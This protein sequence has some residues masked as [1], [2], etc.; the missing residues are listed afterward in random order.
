MLFRLESS[1]CYRSSLSGYTRLLG[2]DQFW[3][4]VGHRLLRGADNREFNLETG[5]GGSL[6]PGLQPLCKGRLCCC[7]S[8]GLLEV[9]WLNRENPVDY[10]LKKAGPT[11]LVGAGQQLHSGFQ[12]IPCSAGTSASPD[13]AGVGG[14]QHEQG[15]L[16]AVRGSPRLSG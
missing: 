16:C 3:A 4:R 5:M 12:G 6:L 1:P 15:V 8:P 14:G 2:S 13:N 7:P 9:T 11:C 10:F